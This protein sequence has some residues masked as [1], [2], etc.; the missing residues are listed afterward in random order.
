VK[1]LLGAGVLAALAL[2]A[3]MPVSAEEMPSAAPFFALTMNT[4]DDKPVV[5]ESLKGKPLIVN[6]WARWCGPCRKEIPDL[7]EMHAKYKGKGLVIIGIGVEDPANRDSVREFAKAYEMSY[8][9]VIGGVQT[10]IELMQA[11]GNPKSGL[12]FTI[13]IDRH[14]KIVAKKLGAMSKA[15]M[16]AAIKQIL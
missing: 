15:D 8:T 6:F 4:P 12:P 16:E 13:V 1:N 2:L 11:I 14:G 7:A 10:S 5:F 9:L 3:A